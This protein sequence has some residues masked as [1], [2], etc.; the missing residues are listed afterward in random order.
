MQRHDT[1]YGEIGEDASATRM[2]HDGR[3]KLIYYPVGNCT[4]LFDLQDDP[5]EQRDLS[6]SAE[7]AQIKARLTSSLIDELYGGDEQWVS[8]QELI[9]L[10]D[11]TYVP[12]PNRGLSGQRGIHWPPP[13][14]DQSGRVVGA[15]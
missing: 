4:Q 10:P 13:P 3:F 7:H 14:L 12:Q 9:G 5:R 11:R 8:D 6:E 1:L 15:P 2:I